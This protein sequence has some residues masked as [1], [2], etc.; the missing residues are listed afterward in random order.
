M[1]SKSEEATTRFGLV[2]VEIKCDPM[3]GFVPEWARA[4]E[5]ADEIYRL[6]DA[7]Y[8][9]SKAND[10]SEGDASS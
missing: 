9:A 5:L 7:R 3:L 10:P 8:R 6:I 4:S 1:Y 2:S